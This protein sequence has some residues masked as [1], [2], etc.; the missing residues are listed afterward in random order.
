MNSKKPVRRRSR[1]AE[2]QDGTLTDRAYREL[3]EMIVTLRLM[4][5]TVS[6]VARDPT[7]DVWAARCAVSETFLDFWL[8]SWAVHSITN[9]L[10]DRLG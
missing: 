4:P 9:R 10:A 8:E 5:A 6:S 3:E 2:P 1:A 7:C